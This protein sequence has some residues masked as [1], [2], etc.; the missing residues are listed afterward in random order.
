M[1]W[2]EKNQMTDRYK[3]EPEYEIAE[4]CKCFSCWEYTGKWL[5]RD[6]EDEMEDLV[7]DSQEE[8]EDWVKQNEKQ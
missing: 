2:E 1:K 8:A 4:G 7:F 3:I 5:V 6:M